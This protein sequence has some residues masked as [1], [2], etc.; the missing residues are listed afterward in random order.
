MIEIFNSSPI[1]VSFI[2]I[3]LIVVLGYWIYIFWGVYHFAKDDVKGHKERR[4]FVRKE[5]QKNKRITEFSIWWTEEKEDRYQELLIVEK[6]KSEERKKQ[7]I[8]EIFD[9][10]KKNKVKNGGYDIEFQF[11]ESDRN[12][13]IERLKEENKV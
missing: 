9:E 3:A 5:K 1:F 11:L 12:R 4:L 6:E 2:V 7:L 13:H 10:Q 8:D